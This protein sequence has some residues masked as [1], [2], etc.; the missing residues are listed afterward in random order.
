MFYTFSSPVV[1]HLPKGF[2][3][4]PKDSVTITFHVLLPKPIWGW[5]AKSEMYIRFGDWQLGNW[6]YNSGPLKVAK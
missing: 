1:D 3:A 6:K 2:K 4:G 5:D